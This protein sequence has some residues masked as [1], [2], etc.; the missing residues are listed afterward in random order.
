[1]QI[2]VP[3]DILKLIEE[4]FAL[5]NTPGRKDFNRIEAIDNKLGTWLLIEWHHQKDRKPK[6]KTNPTSKPCLGLSP[7]AKTHP[8]NTA[9]AERDASSN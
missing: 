8:T 4:Q 2:N 5:I 1:M 6:P 9:D 7:W 3:P